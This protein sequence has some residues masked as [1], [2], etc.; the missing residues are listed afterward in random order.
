MYMT[1]TN[2]RTYTICDCLQAHVGCSWCSVIINIKEQEEK[3]QTESLKG[4]VVLEK[5][6]KEINRPGKILRMSG[7]AIGIIILLGIDF[8]VVRSAEKPSAVFE[9]MGRMKTDPTVYM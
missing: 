1:V 3:I 7:L 8:L 4:E 9:E 6:D 2:T 5:Q